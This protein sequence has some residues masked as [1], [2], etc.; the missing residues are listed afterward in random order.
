MLGTMEDAVGLWNQGKLEEALEVSQQLLAEQAAKVD[1]VVFHA[2]LLLHLRR[3]SEAMTVLRAAAVRF[4]NHASLLTNLSIAERNCGELS[5]AIA[6]AER[7]LTSAPELLSAWNALLLARLEAGQESLAMTELRKA[8]ALH[9]EAPSLRH[10]RIQLE[11]Q[12]RGS[13]ASETAEV[14]RSLMAEARRHLAKGAL[15]SAEAAYR[16][17]IAIQP[18]NAHGHAGLGEL[19]LVKR[20]SEQAAEHF[21]AALQALPEH[22]RARYLLAVAQGQAPPIAPADYVRSLFDGMADTFDDYLKGR[23]AYRVPEE[24][25]RHLV[26]LA[27]GGLGEVLDL[28]CGTGLVGE[29]LAGQSRAV[30]GVDLS[31]EML[32]LARAKGVYRDLHQADMGQF[33]DTRAQTWRTITAADVFIYHGQ[34]DSLFQQI[35]QALEP[36]GLFA[37]SVEAAPGQGVEVDRASGRYQH[38]RDYLLS[39]LSAA[40]LLHARFIETVIRQEAGLPIDGWVVVARKA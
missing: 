28:G 6:S 14:V 35:S 7:A 11:C 17:V 13:S 23:L 33:L 3:F 19:L 36:A 4:P 37:F 29:C 21:S 20:D 25:T 18:D 8:L 34:L 39:S 16:Q 31:P 26:D 38:S 24:I 10:L 12:A 2:G 5:A 15:G 27:A 1:I 32:R 22:A 40:G 30:D 9:P